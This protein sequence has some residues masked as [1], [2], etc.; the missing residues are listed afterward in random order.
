MRN[1]ESN[2]RWGW[3]FRN[4]SARLYHAEPDLH[5][6][7]QAV[8]WCADRVLALDARGR[9]E[10]GRDTSPAELAVTAIT[11]HGKKEAVFDSCTEN[12]ITDVK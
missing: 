5:A 12:S 11:A 10:R 6:Q 2:T 1:R 9:L 3:Q 8:D 4:V 7:V